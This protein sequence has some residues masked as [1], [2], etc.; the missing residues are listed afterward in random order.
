MSYGIKQANTTGEEVDTNFVPTATIDV[1]WNKTGKYNRRR[2]RYKLCPDCYNRDQPYLSCE[3][4]QALF[5]QFGPVLLQKKLRRLDFKTGITKTIIKQSISSSQICRH[6]IIG[7]F[8][9]IITIIIFCF[10]QTQIGKTF[11]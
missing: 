6:S 1:V 2:S 4:N 9:S 11:Y 7:I 3:R 10:V 8:I 5:V